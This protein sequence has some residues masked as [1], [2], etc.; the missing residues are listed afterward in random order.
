MIREYK[1]LGCFLELAE[2]PQEAFDVTLLRK[3]GSFQAF[4]ISG[5]S[6]MFNC[7]GISLKLINLLS[8]APTCLLVEA[9][10]LT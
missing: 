5:I 9:H 8:Y 4:L 2:V 6:F 10:Y 7:D 1:D 3:Q